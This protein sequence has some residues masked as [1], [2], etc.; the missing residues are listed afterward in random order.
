MARDLAADSQTHQFSHPGAQPREPRRRHS[1]F[2]PGT[3]G[4][5]IQPRPRLC[6]RTGQNFTH[7]ERTKLSP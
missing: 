4:E 2:F 7:R 1:G 3:H 6:R 5:S